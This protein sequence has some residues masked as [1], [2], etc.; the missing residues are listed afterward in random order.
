MAKVAKTV[1]PKDEQ[2]WRGRDAARALA[3]AERIKKDP[4]L[5]KLAMKEAKSMY[6]EQQAQ[7][8]AMANII[9]KKPATSKK[10]NKK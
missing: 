3:E 9:S 7:A 4:V 6:E 8:N 5:M 10:T 1:I 2:I